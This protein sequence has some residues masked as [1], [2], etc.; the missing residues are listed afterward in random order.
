MKRNEKTVQDWIRD[1]KTYWQIAWGVAK[2]E[3]KASTD[4]PD[5]FVKDH[6]QKAGAETLVAT[7]KTASTVG[8]FVLGLIFPALVLAFMPVSMPVIAGVIVT[9]AFIGYF[10]VGGAANLITHAVITYL[11][12]DANQVREMQEK[13]KGVADLRLEDGEIF[14]EV[15]LPHDVQNV[16][17]LV[18]VRT[19]ENT[20]LKVMVKGQSKT[21]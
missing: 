6:K 17:D 11:F 1:G 14:P 20:G 18:D 9:G 15:I 7:T 8:S 12:L 2:L 16:E 10:G 13:F 19:L 5:E 4:D 21:V 3:F